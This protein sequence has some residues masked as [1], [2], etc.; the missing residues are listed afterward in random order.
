MVSI[1]ALWL[2]IVV[3]AVVVFVASSIM[4]ML[5]PYHKSDYRKLPDEERVVDCLRASGVTPGPSY[6]FPHCTHKDM[7]SPETIEKFKRG[8]VGLLTLLPSG[9]P[10]MGKYLGL[11][12]GF[13]LLLSF[14]IGL[15][16][17]T[18]FGPGARHHV[19]FHFFAITAFLG[20]GFGQLQD[21]IWKGQTW[22]V[23]LKHL[24]DSLIYALLT[25]EIFSLLWP[26]AIG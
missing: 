21:S 3:A 15:L 24:F 11:W 20:Y 18:T 4:H 16:G 13:C 25:A 22:G 5:L 1:A 6:H 9:P 2:P 17:G 12:F 7:K 23:T 14:V 8:P 10:A 19:I 26:T